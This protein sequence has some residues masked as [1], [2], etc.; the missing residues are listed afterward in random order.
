M[1]NSFLRRDG[2]GGWVSSISLALATAACSA[3]T[4]AASTDIATSPLSTSSATAVK[5][6]LM[7]TLDDSGSMGWSWMP[8]NLGYHNGSDWVPRSDKYGYWSS[9][10]N[11]VG[12]N[13]AITYEL[14][15][16]AAGATVAAGSLSVMDVNPSLFSGT[17]RDITSTAP[18]IGTGS[19]TVTLSG[20]SSGSYAN[21]DI[22]MFY[23]DDSR[24]NWMLGAVTA[25]NSTTDVL[26]I[27]VTLTSGSGTLSS[28]KAARGEAIPLYYSYTGTEPKLG[29]T[30]NSS[31][32]I[33]T[34][35]YNQCMSDIG[36]TPGSSVFTK[37]YVSSTS[38][39]SPTVD[40]RQ[41]YANWYA[42]YRTRMQMMKS[43][44]SLAFKGI[45]DKYRVGFTTIN[46]TGFSGGS[47][48]DI[49]DFDSTQKTTF[50][51]KMNAVNPGSG[52]PLRAALSK[53]GQYYAKKG[54]GQ[55][56]DPVQYSCQKN[57][58]ILSTDGYW[59]TGSESS[60]HGP[61][62]LDNATNVGQQDGT[63]ARPMYDGATTTATTT[64]TWTTTSTTISTVA[65]PQSI[66]TTST[67][68][69]TTVTPTK[70][71]SRNQ[72]TLGTLNGNSI[73]NSDVDIVSGG[74][75]PA[76][77]VCILIETSSNHGYSTGDTIVVSG[78][79][80]SAYN[81]TFTITKKDNNEYYYTLATS[82][83]SE[84][85]NGNRGTSR[86]VVAPSCAAGQGVLTTQA[87]RR[88][89][90]TGSAV[91]TI[92][93]TTTPAISTT[94]TTTVTTT[95]Y[96]HTTT[97]V[98]GSTTVDQTV[99]GIPNTTNTPATTVVPDPSNATTGVSTTTTPVTDFT[100]WTNFG[101][102]TTSC[103][104]TLP[105]PNPSTA[106]QLAGPS[107]TTAVVTG[108]VNSTGGPTTTNGT[109]G[110]PT[111]SGPNT[112]ESAHV[113]NTVTNTSG[114]S[115]NSLADV[116]M[117]YYKTDLRN[118]SLSNCQGALGV[119]TNVCN[120][121]VAPQGNDVATWQHM[122][123]FT[124][125]LGLSGILTYDK[126]YL[127]Q[128]TGDYNDIKQGTKDWP[129][130][131]DNKGAENID[132]LW[133]AAVNGRGQYFSAGDPVTLSTSLSGILA[134]I[135]EKI[136]SASG[137]AASNLQPV[138]GDNKLFVAQYVTGKWIGDVL[139]LTIDPETGVIS[140]TVAWSAKTQLNAM[141]AAGTPRNIY[142]FKKN[143]SGNGGVLRD[144]THA[145]LTTDG[146]NGNVDNACSKSPALSQ[147][148]SLAAGDVTAANS[149]TN[150]VA[151]LRGGYN[152]VYRP[153]ESP[154]GDIIGGAPVFVSKP[155][156]KYTENAYSS[157]ASTNAS[158]AGV[159][160]V[161]ANDGMLHA[162]DGATGNEKWAYMPS[163]VLPN[164]YKL[165]DNS[166]ASNHQY[167]VDGAPSIGDIYVGG[168]WKTILVGGLGAGGRSYYALD[169]TDP[170]NP[171]AMWEFSDTHL[172]LTFGN[173]IITKRADG[174]WIVA[175]GSGYNNNVSGG[176]G[177]GRMYVLNAST[178]ALITS[179]QT[180]TAV[181]TPAGTTTTPSGLA[182]LNVWV[183]S[184]IDNT[185]KR[186]YGGDLLG[187]VWRFDL[188][189]LVA[190]NNAALRL[191]YLQTGSPGVAQP[192]TS[193]VSLA[194]I[195]QSG[196]KYPVVFLGTG[197][198]LGTS[199]LSNTAQQSVY[200]IKDPMTGTGLGD[201]RAGT[202]LVAQTLTTT[203]DADGAKIR[204]ATKNP[205]T[206]S[207]K[208]G[209]YVDLP[210][211]GERV[212]VDPQLLFNTL[213]VA[214]NI[215]STDAC[216]IG[217]E[218]FLYRF[219]IGTG[220]SSINGSDTAGT[221]MGNTMIVGLSFV[222]LKKAGGAA[223]SGDTVTITVDNAGNTGTSKVP[224]PASSVGATKRTSWRE[225]VN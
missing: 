141:V 2:R 195:T 207:S 139:A 136:G 97:V 19:K 158:R 66:A 134:A 222:Q 73:N 165:A 173:P 102:A 12:Y 127:T 154:L 22:V 130:P 156:F 128:V 147:C 35:F 72:Y 145:N 178:G 219:D 148:S 100:T 135:V 133:H 8:D 143:V 18:T 149:G 37:K 78:V 115:T 34:T 67:D 138:A 4:F 162:F 157:F 109:P 92:T 126:N 52:T 218:S 49:A 220:G 196:T 129:V 223:G 131:G 17:V 36:S 168:A 122:T 41:N 206:W 86:R 51:S 62:A 119:G 113:S 215:P 75:C 120:D 176:D 46:T 26:T 106:V 40:E 56:Y 60:S 96:T 144:F 14:P 159:V 214:A 167:L 42:Y 99:A 188:D 209:W 203:T 202:T 163:A 205:V 164:L 15:V 44:V 169:I 155:P 151:W 150:L 118:A 1:S 53:V 89:E 142:Y 112:V 208:N 57:F 166:Y 64:E 153:R 70:G 71:W 174:T 198:Y 187:N 189:N 213:T 27:N 84:P 76:G 123:T 74:G 9:Q 114:G 77:P 98:N 10:C 172:G 45:G 107:N 191:A 20:G 55:T 201:L 212:N 59:N 146:L 32:A 7:F 170:N 21:G 105:S 23:S 16:D 186:F 104:S 171:V 83:G 29:W 116:A 193:Q 225:I 82:P 211:A 81:G 180:Y 184:E 39:I 152:A 140:P 190:P 28:P 90:R 94:V 161:A 183:D 85:S 121:N 192:I 80:P 30:Y 117:Y 63:A 224:D 194:E 88:D 175:F 204:N 200:A 33:A 50:Y 79:T 210:S 3:V 199:D 177:N 101:S 179:I 87:Q 69:T 197:K 61:F 65:T 185:A 25:W 160:Y 221:W 48:L 95:P 13:P 93:T 54:S 5:P 68:T 91:A 132:D 47:F 124:L 137:A 103:A 6:N 31:G 111:T 24:G 11:G 217:G 182:K 216:T 38:G 110:A 125:G 58:N 43:G 181:S 108:P